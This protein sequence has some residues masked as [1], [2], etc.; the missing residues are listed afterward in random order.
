[1]AHHLV[2]GR[3]AGTIDL[4]SSSSP[5]AATLMMA[6]LGGGRNSWRL[7]A[8]SGERFAGGPHI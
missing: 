7:L 2:G 8:S 6:K 5:Y 1:M 4:F 3:P